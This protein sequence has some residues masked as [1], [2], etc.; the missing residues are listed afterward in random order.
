MKPVTLIL[1]KRYSSD[2]Q[3]L[4]DAALKKGWKVWRFVNSDIPASVRES[5]AVIYCETAFAD[6]LAAEL[7]VN[8]AIPSDTLLTKL[9]FNYVKRNI[10]FT[11][12]K[13]FKYPYKMKFI[14]PADYKYF[15]A[16]IYKTGD[17]IPGFSHLQDDDPLLISDVVKF[18]D[19][20]RLFIMNGKIKTGSAYVIDTQFIENQISEDLPNELLE[21][22]SDAI[23]SLERLTPNSYVLDVGKL[24]TGEYAVIEFNPTWA[25]GIYGADATKVLECLESACGQ[26]T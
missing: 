11:T 2:S 10:E 26:L 3:L 9:P 24:D 19:E 8:L 6:Y 17:N 15:P 13:N 20:Y 23:K 16:G 21:F 7:K 12:Y 14:K 22:A 25:S 18:V 1:S 4:Y 5:K